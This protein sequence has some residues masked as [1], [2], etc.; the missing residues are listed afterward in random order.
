MAS[1]LNGICCIESFICERHRQEVALHRLAELLKP[2]LQRANEAITNWMSLSSVKKM[3]LGD[4]W[5]LKGPSP[6]RC[7]IH[8]VRPGSH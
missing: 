2:Q 5:E 6:D 7:G 1:S 3:M 8:H 4:V